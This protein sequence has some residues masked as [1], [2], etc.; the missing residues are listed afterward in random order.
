[1]GSGL[2]IVRVLTAQ[3][4]TDL[5]KAELVLNMKR[6]LEDQLDALVPDG[7]DLEE[8]VISNSEHTETI[9]PE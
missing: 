2:V 5:D 9:E 3:G 1:M 4:F 8:V 7:L 6:I